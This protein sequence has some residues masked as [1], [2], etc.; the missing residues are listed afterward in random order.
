[1]KRLVVVAVCCLMLLD[2]AIRL[3]H[4]QSSVFLLEQERVHARQLF[5]ALIRVAAI[6]TDRDVSFSVLESANLIA[7]F[8]EHGCY[9]MIPIAGHLIEAFQTAAISISIAA[10]MLDS[11]RDV[12]AVTAFLLAHEVGHLQKRLERKFYCREEQ[13][14][15][16]AERIQ[17]ELEADRRG[18]QLLNAL[19]YDGASIAREVLALLCSRAW[20]DCTAT[21]ATHPSFTDRIH[22]IH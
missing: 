5:E 8:F 14:M 10:L 16:P 18:V 3:V 12:A 6:P 9:Q 15:T 1:M 7:A 4:P 11:G 21:I 20:Y 19:G 22:A 17:E 2:G 13:A